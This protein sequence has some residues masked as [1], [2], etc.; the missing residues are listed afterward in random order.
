MHDQRPARVSKKDS[1]REERLEVLRLLES[2]DITA[3]EADTLLDALGAAELAGSRW[4]DPFGAGP[5]TRARNI[6][7]RISDVATGK[8]TINLALPLGLVEAG[9]NVARRFAPDKVPSAE[10][11]KQSISSGMAG[12]LVDVV[13]KNDRIEIMVEH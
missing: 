3:S 13:D 7:F 9:L 10:V 5:A 4:S 11:I 6:R 12:T 8:A 2:G 1:S